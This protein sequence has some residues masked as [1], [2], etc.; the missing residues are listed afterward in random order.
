MPSVQHGVARGQGMKGQGI[1]VRRPPVTAG[2][3]L[4]GG[5]GVHRPSMPGSSVS[6]RGFCNSK[7]KSGVS[8][9]QQN[10]HSSNR[11]HLRGNRRQL[12][13]NRRRLEGN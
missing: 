7:K 3:G 13:G 11:W 12:E 4:V 2:E 5:E 10:L 1:G 6:V 9:G 8:G